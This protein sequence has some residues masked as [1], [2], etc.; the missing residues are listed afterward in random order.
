MVDDGVGRILSK[1]DELGMREN[2]VVIFTSDHGDMFGDHGILLKAGMHYD[3]CVRVP[4]LIDV[5]GKAAGVS[6]SQVGSVDF[7]QTV[8]ILAMLEV[9]MF[10][11]KPSNRKFG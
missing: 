9:R 7:A 4:L 1:L 6:A 10:F 5:P 11:M 3:G 8:S 2:T